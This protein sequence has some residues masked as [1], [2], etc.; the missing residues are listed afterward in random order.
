MNYYDIKPPRL[1]GDRT[2]DGRIAIS[3]PEFGRLV[4]LGR[5]SAFAAVRSGEVP[6]V[7]I[8]GRKFVAVATV[9]KLLSGE[10]AA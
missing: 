2:V 7:Q 5:N 3:V 6:S 8:G 10:S 4:G 9:Q 1:D